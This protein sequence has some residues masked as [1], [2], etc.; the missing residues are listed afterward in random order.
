MAGLGLDPQVLEDHSTK[1]KVVVL[2]IVPYLLLDLN[3]F[4]TAIFRYNGDWEARNFTKGKR[5]G[6]SGMHDLTKSLNHG[7]RNIWY[8]A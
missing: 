6:S 3:P 8:I 2:D 5:D 7:G 1:W 4:G